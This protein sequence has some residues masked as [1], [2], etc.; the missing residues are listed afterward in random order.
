[1]TS[2]SWSSPAA[3]YVYSLHRLRTFRGLQFTFSKFRSQFP[4][5]SAPPTQLSYS[6]LFTPDKKLGHH[7]ASAA[8][9]PRLV[10][11]SNTW[12]TDLTS[13]SEPAYCAPLLCLFNRSSTF[14]HTGALSTATTGLVFNLASVGILLG[15]HKHGESGWAKTCRS[16]ATA[17]SSTGI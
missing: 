3:T 8:T 5:P 13:E 2:V 7:R 4:E 10:E 15:P 14:S 1:M 16:S 12:T 6:L 9:F 17:L 11:R